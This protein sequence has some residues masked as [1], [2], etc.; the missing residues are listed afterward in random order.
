LHHGKLIRDE[1]DARYI[2]RLDNEEL[3]GVS[4]P[5]ADLTPA[6]LDP[7]YAG[8]GDGGAAATATVTQ[9]DP[10]FAGKGE[11]V[12]ATP[13]P[14]IDFADA[15]AVVNPSGLDPAFA[16]KGAQVDPSYAGKVGAAVEN[17]TVRIPKMTRK[18]S[19]KLATSTEVREPEGFETTDEVP[20]IY[21]AYNTEPAPL[22]DTGAFDATGLRKGPP[23]G[24]YVPADTKG[25]N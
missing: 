21:T 22:F 3:D 12:P 24:D 1:A 9:V 19:A 15:Q 4:A 13:S 16:G 25:G 20:D 17:S 11:G 2:S 10:A 6:E 8:E 7:A 18:V 23:T 14:G 5:A